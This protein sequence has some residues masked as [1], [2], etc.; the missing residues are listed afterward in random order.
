MQEVPAQMDAN[1]VQ[2]MLGEG[3]HHRPLIQ[4]KQTGKISSTAQKAQTVAKSAS[5]QIAKATMAQKVGASSAGKKFLSTM[6]SSSSGRKVLDLARSAKTL[7]S[8]FS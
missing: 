5:R 8:A 4:L 2:L 6:A 1:T 7:V 3:P